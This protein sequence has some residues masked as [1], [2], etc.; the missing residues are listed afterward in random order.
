MAFAI[1]SAKTIKVSCIRVWEEVPEGLEWFLV[2]NLPVE[3]EEDALEKIGWYE[4]RWLIEEYHKCLKT[5]CALEKRQL[6]TARGLLAILGF[7]GVIATRLLATKYLAKETPTEKAINHYPILHLHLLA[8]RFD[9]PIEE[10]TCLQYWH[11][12]ARLGGF[13]GR[14]SDGDPGWQTLWKGWL[15]LQDLVEGAELWKKCG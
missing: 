13:I 2:T 6:M 11:S 3:C 4:A 12:I 8:S 5:G 10:M 9:M 1:V 7:L 14:K 15:K